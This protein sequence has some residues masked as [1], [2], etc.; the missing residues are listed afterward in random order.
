M[1]LILLYLVVEPPRAGEPPKK[2]LT[3]MCVCVCVKY[4]SL[5]WIEL[6][7]GSEIPLDLRFNMDKTWWQLGKNISLTSCKINSCLQ[8]KLIQK[9]KLKKK[10]K[11]LLNPLCIFPSRPCSTFFFST[12]SRLTGFFY[13]IFLFSFEFLVSLLPN[14][15][16]L[17]F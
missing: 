13:L 3:I 7:C 5:F 15:T 14:L 8:N 10:K 16:F 17:Y 11:K 6:L 12:L 4:D 1:N 2:K 9:L